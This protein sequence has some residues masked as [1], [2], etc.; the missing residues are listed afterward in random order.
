MSVHQGFRLALDP[1]AGQRRGLA[2]HC[3][4]ARFAFNWGL[5]LVKVR[6]EARGE[7]GEAEVPWNLPAL[8]REWNQQKEEVAPWWRE[9]SK[10]AYSSGLDALARALGNFSAAR[11]GKR[12]AS[13]GF[14]RHRKRGRRDSCRFTT[15]VIRI[16]DERHVSL[17]RL[18]RLRT[19]EE[20][21]GLLERLRAGTARILSATVSREADRW[22][23]SFTCEVERVVAT[24]NGH[25]DVVGVDLGV[26][27]L[28]TLSS[29]ELIEG[30]V[31][32]RSAQ[33]RL[34]RQ[35]RTVSRRHKGS[36]RRRRAAL[37]VA[38][39]HRR[40]R[41]VRRDR[42]HKLTTELA[43]NHG[44]VVIEDL[45][46]RGMMGSARG[47]AEH[48]GRNVRAKAGLNRALADASLGEF[49]RLLEYKCAWY[50]STL[51]MAPRLFASSKRCS[52]CGEVREELSL[53]ERV[54]VCPACGQTTD[55]DLNAAHNLVW[56]AE[57]NAHQV[58]ASAVE[59]E[60]ARGEDLR[61][62]SSR[63]DLGEARTG[64]GP[65]PAGMT[66]GPQRGVRYVP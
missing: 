36:R 37:R 29:G 12:R 14:P 1:T 11:H 64:N 63:A 60:N 21:E 19:M 62:G 3:G 7:D 28:A 59:T 54:F 38:R 8:R 4:A 10:E 16:D 65:E 41:N 34:R 53:G 13:S 33:R 48:P 47:T 24:S 25:D 45:N 20:T 51:V 42:L 30:A 40:V 44:R 61:P 26:L 22:F 17:P 32:L 46:V 18:G 27:R 39:T 58:A 9:N 15:G 55:R 50:G 49:R 52:G 35:Q 2:S 57:A 5:E 66:G 56:W 23:V 43:K 31:G 6:L